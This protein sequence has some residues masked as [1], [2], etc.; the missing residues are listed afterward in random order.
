MAA[1]SASCVT[2]T[3]VVPRA[4]MNLAQ[5]LHDV[6]AGGGVEVAGR[7]VG[8]HDRRIVGQRA[9][10]RDPLLFASRQLRRV[11]MRAA[12]QSDLF[13]QRLRPARRTSG[14]PAISIGTAT[15]SYAVSDGIR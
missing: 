9:G 12:G 8:Q 13:E 7:L 15:F 4:A 3:I 2:R 6:A 14:A 5:Q 10:E 1:S 11:V